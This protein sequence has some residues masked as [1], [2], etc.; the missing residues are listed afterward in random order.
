MTEENKEL[1]K[2]AIIEGLSN[3]I[4][5]RIAECKE[6]IVPSKKHKIAMNRIFWEFGFVPFSEVGEVENT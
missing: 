2:R 3:K 1:F 4:D 6:E 5:E